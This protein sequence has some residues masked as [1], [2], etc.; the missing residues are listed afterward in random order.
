MK[1]T[2][3]ELVHDFKLIVAV[4]KDADILL[5]QM[6]TKYYE[7]ELCNNPNNMGNLKVLKDLDSVLIRIKNILAQ[8]EINENSN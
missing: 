4:Q 7:K 8:G 6:L 3:K 2:K 1:F 5:E